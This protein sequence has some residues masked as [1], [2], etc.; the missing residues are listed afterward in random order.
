MIT[1]NFLTR[2]GRTVLT[3]AAILAAPILTGCSSECDCDN[4]ANTIP[5]GMARLNIS[6]STPHL[7]GT[8]ASFSG[9]G[10]DATMRVTQKE[11]TVESLWLYIFRAS[12]GS[13]YHSENLAGNVTTKTDDNKP[14]ISS[15]AQEVR[16]ALN[17]PADKYYFYMLANVDYYLPDGFGLANQSMTKSDLDDLKLQFKNSF[18]DREEALP[19]AALI[20]DFTIA[21]G[22]AANN[23]TI[24]DDGLVDIKNGDVTLVANMTFLCSAVRY[25]FLFDNTA[26]TSVGGTDQGFSF[27]YTSILSNSLKVSKFTNKEVPLTSNASW[28]DDKKDTDT[29]E[30][31]ITSRL[32]KKTFPT[33]L[34][35]WTNAPDFLNDYTGAETTFTSKIAYQGM[36]YLPENCNTTDKTTLTWNVTLDG[37]T[38]KDFTIKLPNNGGENCDIHGEN[39]SIEKGDFILKRGHFYDVIGKVTSSGVAFY[40][41]VKKWEDGHQDRF[42]L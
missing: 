9:T 26:P 18:V 32:D 13:L 12:D 10:D 14:Y 27:P 15:T 2:I 4:P 11:A 17:I 8:K 30:V 22:T 20:K 1:H 6:V 39:S 3:A 21:D 41:K 33:T 5:E 7:S 37:K 24:S 25:T 23:V 29:D 40:V 28:S 42:E 16:S 19:M 34:S 35:D 38:N 31:P 36:V